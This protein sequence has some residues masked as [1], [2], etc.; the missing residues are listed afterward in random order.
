MWGTRT[1]NH[2]FTPSSLPVPPTMSA[3][4][5]AWDDAQPRLRTIRESVKSLAPPH[6]RILRVGQ[7][8]A[9][10]LDQELVHLLQ[11]PLIKALALIH[12]GTD[13]ALLL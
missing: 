1:C 4:Q 6:A 12:V 8:D 2:A 7:L 3:L 13:I 5:Q 11:D 10:L 9:E